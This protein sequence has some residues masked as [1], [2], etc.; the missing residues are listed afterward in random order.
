M[1]E[2]EAELTRLR[3][4]VATSGLIS[5]EAFPDGSFLRQSPLCGPNSGSSTSLKQRETWPALPDLYYRML[6]VPLHEM[7]LESI[8]YAT[9]QTLGTLRFV[10][11]DGRESVKYGEM[12][13]V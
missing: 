5:I 11:N 2:M 10:F 8:A 4:Q 6:E 3:E 12:L 9:G 1:T 13:Q 7:R